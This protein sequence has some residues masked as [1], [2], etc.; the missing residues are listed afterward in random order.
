[1]TIPVRVFTEQEILTGN[2]TTRYYLNILDS[3]DSVIDRLDGVVDGSVDWVA[4]ALVKGGGK[5]NVKD[6]NQTIDWLNVRLQP[7]MAIQGLAEHPLGV[8]LAAEAPEEWIARRS[9]AVKLLDKTTILDQDIITETY[10]LAAGTV[11]TTA[12]VD[13]LVAM[14]ITSHSIT[15]SAATLPAPLTW[16]PGTSKLRIINDLLSIIN[17]FS[18]YSNEVGQMIGEPYVLPA[19]RPI[20]YEFLDDSRSIYSP[21]FTRDND[22]W[23]IPN[24]VVIT[25]QGDGTT[26]ALISSLDNTDPDSPYSIANRGRVIGYSEEGVE[27]ADQAT[28]DAYARRKLVDLTTSTASVVITHAPLPGLNVN[29]TVRF[30]HTLAGIDARHTVSKTEIT[31]KGNALALTTLREVVDL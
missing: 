7:V 6:V 2:R 31:L 29:N 14:G 20:V 26:A 28:L 22:I 9:W 1:M 12:I 11:V 23:N 18:M 30:R 19:L 10:S 21:E 17:Y 4:N 24:R 8:F 3:N 27:A 15:T 5:L 16:S 13:I 25:G